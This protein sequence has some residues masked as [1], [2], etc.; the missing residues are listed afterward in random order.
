MKQGEEELLAGA[1]ELLYMVE[2][3]EWTGG[4]PGGRS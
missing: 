2:T 4:Y 1:R 3:A